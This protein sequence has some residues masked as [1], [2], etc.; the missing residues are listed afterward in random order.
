MSTNSEKEVRKKKA[1][2]RRCKRG[3]VLIND[4]KGRGKAAKG[5]DRL[6]KSKSE[7][8]LL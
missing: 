2:Q 8:N 5:T 7:G 3:V 4:K 6:E 1:K